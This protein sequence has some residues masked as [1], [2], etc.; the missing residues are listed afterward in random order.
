[1][2]C[3]SPDGRDHLIDDPVAVFEVISPSTASK[4]RVTKLREYKSVSSIR[5]HVIIESE[6]RAITVLS[7]EREG[8]DFKAAGLTDDDNREV[9]ALGVAIPLSSIYAGVVFEDASS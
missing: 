9:P 5:T 3:S 2:T 8:E 4:D 1:M 6:A 7:R